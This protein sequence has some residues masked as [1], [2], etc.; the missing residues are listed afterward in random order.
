MNPPVAH[1]S[2]R[3]ERRASPKSARVALLLLVA[4]SLPQ[5]AFVFYADYVDSEYGEQPASTLV[6]LTI[7]LPC[8]AVFLGIFLIFQAG[9]A[10][11]GVQ[12]VAAVALA[13]GWLVPIFVATTNYGC[14]DVSAGSSPC[15]VT[16]TSTA[17]ELALIGIIIATIVTGAWLYRKIVSAP[18]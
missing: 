9:S 11:S 6:V 8:V 10:W 17:R 3:T 12:K 14:S 4:A 15:S 1:D 2:R 5:P 13:G 18:Q 7:V 16:S